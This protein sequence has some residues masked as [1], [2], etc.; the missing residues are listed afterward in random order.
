[1]TR[2]NAS[3]KGLC[4]VTSAKLCWGD[5]VRPSLARDSE[6]EAVG[7]EQDQTQPLQKPSAI[8]K[9]EPLCSNGVVVKVP[10]AKSLFLS[11]SLFKFGFVFPKRPII[12]KYLECQGQKIMSLLF[13]MMGISTGSNVST[14]H[15]FEKIKYM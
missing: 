5:A 9:R 14:N 12:K 3:S 10:T 2:R 7:N 6:E 8:F 11:R 15:P 1:M 4:R 13:H